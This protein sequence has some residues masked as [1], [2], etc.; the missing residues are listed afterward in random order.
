MFV[1]KQ[2]HFIATVA[3]WAVFPVDMPTSMGKLCFFNDD[4]RGYKLAHRVGSVVT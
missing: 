2:V 3:A 1:Y 4:F